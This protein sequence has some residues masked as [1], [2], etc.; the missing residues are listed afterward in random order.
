M[1]LL[2]TLLQDVYIIQS[3]AFYDQRGGFVKL[4]N[5]QADLLQNYNIKQVNFVQNNQKGILRGLHYQTDNFAESKFF[6]ALKGS[7]QLAFVDLRHPVLGVEN[8]ATFILDKPNIGVLIPRGF[9]TG[10]LTLADN[11]DVLYYSDNT[12][13]PLSERGIRWNDPFFKIPWL[14]SHP[15]L[16][17]KDLDWADFITPK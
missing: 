15:D 3:P 6:R 7:I 8:V 4:F 10:Y 13:N 5:Q 12:Y 1:E 14:A 16:S 2:Q 9:A 17:S 11:T